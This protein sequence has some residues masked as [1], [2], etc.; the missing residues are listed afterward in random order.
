M[1][2]KSAF[3][4]LVLFVSI[5]FYGQDNLSQTDTITKLSA[6]LVNPK[7]QSPERLP[8]I[9]NNTLFSGKKNEVVRLSSINGNFAT[10]NARE[11]F[12]RIP[13]VNIWENEGSGIQINV[14]VRGLSPNRSWELNTRQNGYDISSDVFGYPEAYYNPPME[15]VETIELV[16]GGASLQF[17]PQFGGMLNYVLKRETEKAFTFETQNTVGS[18]GLMSSYNAI[19]G[20]IKKFSYYAYNHSRS[21]DGWR[22]NNEYSVRNTHAF[23]EYRFTDKTKVSAE[24]T[25]MNYDMQQPGG[26]TDAQYDKNLRQSVRSRNWLGTPWNVF[27]LNFDTKI[28]S[29]LS[30][31]TKLFGLVGERNSVGF[32]ATP[33]IADAISPETNSLANRR[34]DRDFYKNF[35]I[36]NRN[37]LEYGLGQTKQNLAFGARL[38]KA[39]TTRQQQGRG[40]TASDFDLS[41]EGAYPRDL[42]FTTENVAL[43]A[44]N[45]FRLTEKFSVTPGIRY[46]H[47]T[48]VGQG[49]FS[50]SQG[51]DIAMPEETLVRN[52]ALFG[53]GMEYKFRTTNVYANIT[54]AFRPVLFSDLT[55]PAVTDVID[56]N[57]KDASGFNADLGFRGNFKNFL[58]FDVSLFYLSYNNRIGGMPQFVN[59]DPSQGTFLFRTNLGETVNKGIEGFFNLNVTKLFDMDKKYANLD[60]FASMSFIDSRYMD[61]KTF[62]SSG[63]GSNTIITENNLSG[64]RVENAPRYIHNLGLSWSNN[65]FST[66]MQY[67]LSGRVFTDAK[68][69]TAPSANGVT[70]LLDEYHVFDLSTEYKFLRNYNLKAGINNVFN[71]QYATRRA[72]GYP[73]PGILPG[74]A[75][76]FYLSIGAKF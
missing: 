68:N 73:G 15:A 26:L 10:N 48:S 59:N 55:P 70:G 28:T 36:E 42:D 75:Q 12:S 31:N 66:T 53:L 23:I 40:T 27:S 72:S 2:M 39:N 25:N 6:V 51:N 34:V 37:V 71:E 65:Q 38:Y 62:T 44:E 46:E 9:K 76:T 35:G 33:N 74:E 45:Q 63:T 43:F 29:K 60:F 4:L 20:T 3:S 17:G 5:Q 21:A 52:K 69:T 64:N 47:I 49:R 57:L 18:Y 24:Y 32:T 16:R 14:S 22:E 1:K 67:R 58:N 13:G 7:K 54:Q 56:P 61:F 50:V 30:S 8:E 41:V 11:I 19:G